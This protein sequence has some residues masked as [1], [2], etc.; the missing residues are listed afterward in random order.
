MR[1]PG[2][3]RR[4]INGLLSYA[5]PPP[6]QKELARRSGVGERSLTQHLGDMRRGRLVTPDALRLGPG[7]GL[8]VAIAVD[9]ESVVAATVDANGFPHHVERTAPQ[10]DLRRASAGDVLD[11]IA[12]VATRTWSASKTSGVSGCKV[13]QRDF[14]GVVVGLPT[15]VGRDR[16]RPWVRGHSLADNHWRSAPFEE[17]LRHRLPSTSFGSDEFLIDALNDANCDAMAVVFAEARRDPDGE[18]A[19]HSE[20]FLIVRIA[21]GVGAGMV[22]LARHEP[23]GPFRLTRSTLLVGS[24]GVSG[25]IGHLSVPNSELSRL[26]NDGPLRPLKALPCSCGAKDH[27]EGCIGL[28]ALA[29]RLHRTSPRLFRLEE[30]LGPQVARLLTRRDDTVS[31]ALSD[32]GSILGSALASSILLLDPAKVVLTGTLG[33]TEVAAAAEARCRDTYG[34][35]SRARFEPVSAPMRDILTV[36]GAGVAAFRRS[37]FKPL[38]LPAPRQ[39]PA[40]DGGGSRTNAPIGE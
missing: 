14:R 18:R 24:G 10:I 36:I 9:G 31:R 1:M 6:T 28:G 27:L 13:S 8:F 40:L 22:R 2:T 25:E 19:S 34:L 7:L 15:P 5:D 29:N 35:T 21:C 3:Y 33:V 11:K 20:V 32:A 23:R 30:P 39:L 38:L 16:G 37:I 26:S 12:D 17:L 4:A